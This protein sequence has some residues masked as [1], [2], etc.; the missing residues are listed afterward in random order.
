MEINVSQHLKGTIG[1]TR[2]YEINA[3][4]DIFEDGH[5][6][7]VQ[8]EVRLTR[9]NRGILVK[10]KLNT[11]V[12]VNCSRCLSAFTC[13]LV[14]NIEEEYFPVTDVLTGATLALPDEPGSFTIS[15]RH[16][17]DLTEAVRQ[18]A[19]IAIPMK[20]LCREDCAGLVAE[21]EKSLD[22]EDCGCFARQVDPRWSKL[23]DLK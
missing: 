17:L 19:I 11:E 13:P 10:G 4:I 1:F 9:T 6:S 3:P 18:Y 20:P 16:I 15:E 23:Q 12:E 21:C 8:G 14:L 5:T 22:Q 2:C 7:N